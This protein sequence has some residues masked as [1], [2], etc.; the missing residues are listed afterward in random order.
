MRMLD[1]PETKAEQ[2][3]TG[4]DS[5]AMRLDGSQTTRRS[6]DLR[7]S[8]YNVLKQALGSKTLPRRLVGYIESAV[9]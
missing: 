8:D 7:L 6:I 1:G 9:L 4:A 3:V 2:S 5:S